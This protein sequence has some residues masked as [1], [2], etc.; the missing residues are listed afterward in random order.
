MHRSFS[1]QAIRSALS[2]PS[3]LAATLLLLVGVA[4]GF[5]Q[6]APPAAPAP[7]VS[8]VQPVSPA[9]PTPT[10]AAAPKPTGPQPKLVIPEIT[11]DAKDVAKGD[12]I[13][14]SFTLRNEGQAD[15]MILQV[16]P[17]CGCTAPD[18]T[19]IVPPGG[20]GKIT[21]KVDTAKFKG[22]ISKTANVTTNDPDQAS[23]RLTVN[24]QVK[25]FIDV[26][27]QDRVSFRQY[28]G[29]TKDQTLTI[30]SNEAGEFKINAVEVTGDG[31]KHEYSKA[32]DGSGDYKLK[33]WL[34]KTAPIGNI[35]GSIKIVTN[36]AKEPELTIPVQGNVLGQLSVNPSSLYFRVDGSG[37]NKAWQPT[38]DN[39]NLRA[40]GDA[41]GAVVSKLGK[42]TRLTVVENVGDWA[43]VKTDAN[44]P[45]EGW[46]SAKLIAES[47]A[48]AAVP[49]DMSKVLSI[50]HRDE[51]GNF[52]IT[53]TAVEG[54]KLDASLLKVTTE[55]V[56]A[57]QSY[58]VT[59]TYSGNLEKGNYTG[60]LVV[61]TTD[62]EEPEIKVPVYIVVA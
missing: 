48:A 35:S 47:P 44:P 32:T 57:G 1:S 23:F 25:T 59:V 37:A 40:T 22:P 14:H 36:S 21:L 11:F 41:K 29:E 7:G 16:A 3:S 10:P 62:K 55:S 15:L 9:T 18:W 31:V 43:H 17:A 30:H 38:T 60:T 58:R 49:A 2:R 39:L 4:P 20:T 13:E 51:A 34:D 50:T 53:G 6:S 26:L 56:R 46:V 27:P 24:A 5:A 28:R 8:A 52:Q 33:V 45:V 42:D 61:K 19:K 12:A 54:Q